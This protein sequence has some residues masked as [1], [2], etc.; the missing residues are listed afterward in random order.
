MSIKK[1]SAEL[2]SDDKMNMALDFLSHIVVN[3][4]RALISSLTSLISFPEKI[5]DLNQFGLLLSE[6][7][8]DA[9]IEP[10]VEMIMLAE[11]GKS[12]Y[13]ASY[14]HSLN[15]IIEDW[16]EYFTPNGEF[17]H[18]LGKWMLNTNG[19]EISWK[20][21]L[22]LKDTEHSACINF[23]LEGINDKTLFNQ[24][25]IACLE[26]LVA[27]HGEKNLKFLIGLVPDSD[28]DFNE[29]LNKSIE[30]LKH[31]FSS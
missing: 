26:G 25:R 31:K 13:L 7:K 24:T 12:K 2:C 9:F 17:V 27:H 30:W 5:A 20:S 23:Y 8:D 11:P 16:D 10:L 19:G 29:E 28:P 14:M 18:L 15:C 22:I 4:D 6:I 3:T 1:L 21:S